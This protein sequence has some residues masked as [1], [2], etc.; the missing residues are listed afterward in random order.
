MRS[1]IKLDLALNS[2]LTLD[3]TLGLLVVVDLTLAQVSPVAQRSGS[4]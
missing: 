2:D 1:N 3:L 4:G